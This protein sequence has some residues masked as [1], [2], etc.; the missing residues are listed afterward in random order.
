MP[1]KYIRTFFLSWVLRVYGIRSKKNRLTSVD[2]PDFKLLSLVSSKRDRNYTK[3]TKF[4][5]KNTF[6]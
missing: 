6:F 3:T 4:S 5:K 1:Q 2:C